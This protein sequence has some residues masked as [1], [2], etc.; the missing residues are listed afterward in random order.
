MRK[1]TFADQFSQCTE[2][3]V[4]T[5]LF[6]DLLQHVITNLREDNLNLIVHFGDGVLTLW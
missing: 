3:R 4:Q 5:A 1:S 6:F 2:L